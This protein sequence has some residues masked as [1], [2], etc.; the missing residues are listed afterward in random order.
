MEKTK[1]SAVT[2]IMMKPVQHKRSTGV[3]NNK[4][5]L[6]PVRK[7]KRRSVVSLIPKGNKKAQALMEAVQN[8]TKTTRKKLGTFIR[9]RGYQYGDLSS[10]KSFTKADVTY[11]TRPHKLLEGGAA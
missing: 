10:F 5:K 11:Y 8:Q 7:Q 4:E 6:A 3:V 2:T 9:L 1:Q